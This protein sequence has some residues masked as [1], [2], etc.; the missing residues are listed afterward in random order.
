MDLSDIAPA[1]ALHRRVL[2]NT[3]NA[4]VGNEYLSALYKIL[5][6]DVANS[7]GWVVTAE[8][9]AVIGFLTATL[10]LYSLEGLIKNKMGIIN[11]GR[12]VRHILLHPTRLACL[13]GH[14][15]LS[16]HLLQ[17]HP[18][19]YPTILTIGIDQDIQKQGLGRKLIETCD[20]YFSANR[21]KRYFV[22]TEV[23]NQNAIVFYIKCG[24]TKIDLFG[25][26]V[27][28]EKGVE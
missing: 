1:V 12:I 7:A 15:R 4:E 28:F 27:I 6:N 14:I 2:G 3:F 23:L 20:A 21:V 18:H 19:Q 8:D 16:R 10:N 9:T 22:D 24:F 11:K 26:N 13:F 17:M 25:G 5:I